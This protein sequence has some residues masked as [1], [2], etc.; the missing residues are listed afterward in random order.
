MGSNCEKCQDFYNDAPWRPAGS[1]DPHVCRS[2]IN[3]QTTTLLIIA[4]VIIV[5]GI[6]RERENDSQGTGIV[7]ENKTHGRK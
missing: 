3:V 7:M 4:A 6:V 5:A 1:T 2:K